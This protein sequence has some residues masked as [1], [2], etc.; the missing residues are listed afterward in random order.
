M[1]VEASRHFKHEHFDMIFIDARHDYDAVVEDCFA[2]L[3]KLKR[4]GV[5]GGHDFSY[6]PT[7]VAWFDV[8]GSLADVAG[9]VIP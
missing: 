1:S 7:G 3:P 4:K 5:F 8:I 9:V 6:K 2:W